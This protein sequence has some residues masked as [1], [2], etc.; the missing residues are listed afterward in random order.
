MLRKKRRHHVLKPVLKP[1]LKLKLMLTLK[2][3]CLTVGDCV[4][5]RIAV[6]EWAE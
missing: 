1:M 5:S 6:E 3:G 4:L 2:A